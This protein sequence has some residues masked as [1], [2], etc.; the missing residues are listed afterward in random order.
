MHKSKSYLYVA[1][2]ILVG[3]GFFFHGAQKIFGWFGGKGLL[4][5]SGQLMFAG[6]VEIIVGPLIILGL[7]T[8]MAATLGALNMIGAWILVHMPNGINP[9]TNGGELAM[10]YFAA[11]LVLIAFGASKLSLERLLFKKEF[12]HKS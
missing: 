7:F 3:L 5:L 12:F 11:F 6:F 10:M 1:F 4:E 9:M 8:S 2:R